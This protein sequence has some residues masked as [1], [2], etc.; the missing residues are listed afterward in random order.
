MEWRDYIPIAPVICRH[1]KAS[2]KGTHIVVAGVLEKLAAGVCYPSFTPVAIQAAS[3]YAAIIGFHG[4]AAEQ[5]NN[6]MP[7]GVEIRELNHFTRDYI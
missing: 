7:S 5:L 1:G 4:S 6:I 3:N 2:I